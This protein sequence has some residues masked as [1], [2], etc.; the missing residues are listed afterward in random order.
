M[1]R[2]PV[3]VTTIEVIIVLAISAVTFLLAIGLFGTRT[4]VAQDDAARQ[5]VSEIARVRNEAQQG[6]G[7]STSEGKALLGGNELFGQAIELAGVNTK[8]YKLMKTPSG[9][10]TAYESYEIPLTQQLQWWI[11][12]AHGGSN[13]CNGFSSCYKALGGNNQ[14]PLSREP[15]KLVGGQNVLLIFKNNTGQSYVFGRSPSALGLGN[16]NFLG[17]ANDVANY[18]PDRQGELRVAY[19][20]LG[21]GATASEQVANAT[22]KYYLHFD[23]SVPNDQ[24]FEVVQ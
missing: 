13:D 20:V 5:V 9:V 6:L 14:Q 24:R 22:A 7:P 1:R 8:V 17:L 3:G 12:P 19:A 23:L 18:I 4:R 16:N 11:L 2:R 10:I 15:I 21:S